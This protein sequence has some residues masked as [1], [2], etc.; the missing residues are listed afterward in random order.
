MRLDKYL[1]DC[2]VGTRSE[3]KKMIKRGEVSVDGASK[4][5][6]DLKLDEETAFVSVM[7][8][9]IKYRKYVYL[10]LNKPKDVISATYDKK[11]P[12]VAELIPPE[13]AHYEL[14]PVGRLDIDTT[15]LLILTNDGG[16]AHR[17]LSPS[18]HIPKT[19]IAK[20]DTPLSENDV[21]AFSENMDL[22]DFVTKPAELVILDDF[23]AKVTI[24]EGKFHQVKRMFEKTGKTVLDLKRIKMNRL[25]L[26]ESLD[27]GEVR[28][29]NDY[30][31]ELL[32]YGTK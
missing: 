11:L 25:C 7:G 27:I 32:T 1:A 5:T 29:L 4:V 12:T 31:L 13:Y 24:S 17:L 6:P 23:T 14:F 22:G 10:M 16:L 3:I 9:H 18:K 2:G 19:Y 21:K 26:D 30:E 28:E 15:G 8:N 20:L